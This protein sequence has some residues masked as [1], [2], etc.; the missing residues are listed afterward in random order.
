MEI[1]NATEKGNDGLG[2]E[3]G[4]VLH[5]GPELKDRFT[6]IEGTMLIKAQLQSR[7]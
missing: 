3:S 7:A 4:R 5:H 6:K 2:S 1:D